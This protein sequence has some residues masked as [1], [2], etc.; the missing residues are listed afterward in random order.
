MTHRRSSTSDNNDPMNKADR[1]EHS[2]YMKSYEAEM[3]DLRTNTTNSSSSRG[4]SR[5]QTSRGP[6]PSSQSIIG[7]GERGSRMG[8]SQSRG[9]ASTRGPQRSQSRGPQPQSFEPNQQQQQQRRTPRDPSCSRSVARSKSRTRRSN[10]PGPTSRNDDCGDNDNVVHIPRRDKSLSRGNK[11]S[12]ARSVRSASQACPDDHIT[13]DTRSTKSSQQRSVKSTT[14]S[15]RQQQNQV[16]NE[17][18]KSSKGTVLSSSSS[19]TPETGPLS[20]Y[21]GKSSKGSLLK[22]RIIGNV[23]GTGGSIGGSYRMP[24]S[25]PPRNRSSRPTTPNSFHGNK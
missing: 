6:G 15:S 1:E 8:R 24:P 20:S 10:T 4:R 11:S 14:S 17:P 9:A 16:Y 23:T 21:S 3:K 12:S 2:Q 7:G 13:V 18:M 25:T 5:S 22:S 19:S